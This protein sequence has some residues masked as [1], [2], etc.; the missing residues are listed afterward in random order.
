MNFGRDS[1]KM[2]NSLRSNDAN[3]KIISTLINNKWTWIAKRFEIKERKVWT[4]YYSAEQQLHK[5]KSERRMLK[6]KEDLLRMKFNQT[7]TQ[8]EDCKEM[9]LVCKQLMPPGN[10]EIDPNVVN[11]CLA[12]VSTIS[13]RADRKMVRKN[14]INATKL[15]I[16]RVTGKWRRN[17]SFF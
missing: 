8:V 9:C 12:L 2:K 6:I 4:K 14:D 3:A 10:C 5:L 15:L 13:T 7:K 17:L 16:L 1:G 11:E